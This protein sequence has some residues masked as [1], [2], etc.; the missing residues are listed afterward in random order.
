MKKVLYALS[1]ISILMLTLTSG[2]TMRASRAGST[3]PTPT[4]LALFDAEQQD[5]QIVAAAVASKPIS[6]AVAKAVSS[7]DEEETKKLLPYQILT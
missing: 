5:Q 3:N 4:V 7:D 6:P 1:L 2:C